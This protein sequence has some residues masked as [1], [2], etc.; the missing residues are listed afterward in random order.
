MDPIEAG[1]M[2]LH[3]STTTWIRTVFGAQHKWMALGYVLFGFTCWIYHPK[4]E[5]ELA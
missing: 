1:H 2:S 5:N 3:L 4:R